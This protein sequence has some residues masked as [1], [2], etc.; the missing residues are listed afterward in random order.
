MSMGTV[1]PELVRVAVPVNV[2]SIVLPG[3]VGIFVTVSV[4]VSLAAANVI[5]SETVY[6]EPPLQLPVKLYWIV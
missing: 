4:A 5:E 6:E 2:Q 1:D 3:P